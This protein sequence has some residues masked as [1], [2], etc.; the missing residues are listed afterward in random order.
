M[1]EKYWLYLS[2]LRVRIN[3]WR[4]RTSITV[5]YHLRTV[6]IG[7]MCG[8]EYL[9]DRNAT[10]KHI[11]ATNLRNCRLLKSSIQA[12]CV[13]LGLMAYDTN[14][15]MTIDRVM[16]GH[17]TM[18]EVLIVASMLVKSEPLPVAVALLHCKDITLS[19]LEVS[20]YDFLDAYPIGR[21][22]L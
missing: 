9:V 13:T 3:S 18:D 21:C 15:W 14:L 7:R 1:F 4:I 20:G 11:L 16:S 12:E 10:S 2:G 8:W 6:L 5:G 22:T 17:G 19:E